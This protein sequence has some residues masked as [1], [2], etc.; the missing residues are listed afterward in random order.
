MKR[1]IFQFEMKKCDFRMKSYFS[2][3]EL[4]DNDGFDNFLIIDENA[5]KE[6]HK[7][8]DIIVLQYQ[9]E[10]DYKISRGE[11]LVKEA[12]DDI[13][14]YHNAQT[15]RGSQGTPII[16]KD[17]LNV[18]IGIHL[19]YIRFSSKITKYGYFINDILKSNKFFCGH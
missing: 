19:G 15:K 17:K 14:L 9:G 10:N 7:N 6:K 16:L 5:F 12:K 18:V 11:I 1:K 2:C 8:K 13:I 4:F 3:I